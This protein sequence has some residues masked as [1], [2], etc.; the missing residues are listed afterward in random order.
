MDVSI[1]SD[2]TRTLTTASKSNTLST[3]THAP[4]FSPASSARSMPVP[5]TLP[6]PNAA[7]HAPP[8]SMTVMSNEE[9]AAEIRLY[10][11]GSS[12]SLPWSH[13]CGES[14]LFRSMWALSFYNYLA[15]F[16]LS[17]SLS[18]TTWCTNI[19]TE[20][21]AICMFIHRQIEISTDWIVK[22]TY[23]V[24]ATSPQWRAMPENLCK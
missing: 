4:A 11:F 7:E 2:H 5:S 1:L 6:L 15:C 13:R 10:F 3:F 22:A 23:P 21:L 20:S 16:S 14:D 17:P 24:Q 9:K 19:R 12:S 8:T 18:S